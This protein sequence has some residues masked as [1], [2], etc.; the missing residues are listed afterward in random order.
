MGMRLRITPRTP[1][2]WLRAIAAARERNYLIDLG[3]ELTAFGLEK[4]AQ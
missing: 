3:K 2:L 4:R 1:G